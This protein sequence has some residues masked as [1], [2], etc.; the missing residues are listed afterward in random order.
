MWNMKRNAIS[1]RKKMKTTSRKLDKRY[2]TIPN[3]TDTIARQPETTDVTVAFTTGKKT[4]EML[5]KK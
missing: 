2:I 1:V 4:S 5:S 3:S